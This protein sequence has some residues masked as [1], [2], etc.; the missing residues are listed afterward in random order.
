MEQLLLHLFFYQNVKRKTD[1]DMKKKAWHL[2]V[3]LITLTLFIGMLSAKTQAATGVYPDVPLSS[4]WAKPVYWASENGYVQGY[5][6][7]NFG[8]KD[9]C[10]RSQFVVILWRMAGRPS[11]GRSNPFS[12]VNSSMSAYKAIL[13]AVNSGIIKGYSDGTFRPGN[14]VTRAQVVTM[15]WRKAGR[16]SASGSGFPDV[17]S[18]MSAYRAIM[19]ASGRKVVKGYSNGRFGPS[20]D[21]TRAQIVTMFYRYAR[22]IEGKDVSVVLPGTISDNN[23][24]PSKNGTLRVKGARLVDE[25]GNDVQLRGISTHGLAWFPQYVNEACFKYFSSQWGANLMRL[26][27]YTAEYGGY[28]TGGNKSD[29]LDLIDRGV[30]YADAADMY[31]IIDWHIL[32]DSDPNIYKSEAKDFWK[33][34]SAKY[35]DKKNVLYEICNEP[36]GGTSWSRIKSYAEEVIKVIRA[37]DPDAVIIIGTPNWSQYVDQAAADPVKTSDNLMYTLHFYADTHRESLRNTAEDAIKKGLPIFVT[38]FGIC[39]A[40][41]SGAVNEGQADAWIKLLDKYNISYAAWNLS[42]KNETSAIIRPECSKT[43]GFAMSDFS[44]SGKWLY[45][46]LTR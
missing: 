31:V 15:L 8:P 26:A 39:D 30:K 18:S 13:W 32:S 29:L 22:D 12:D 23:A 25:K 14:P 28:C 21:C 9:N 34:I 44:Q 19:W 17:N 10:T 1:S 45:K 2:I 46:T 35:K 40:S 43:S 33:K 6:N 36:N 11:S 24:R 37:N 27:M 3:L 7:G 5:K 38:E 42:N 4:S 41:G 20:D 16:P